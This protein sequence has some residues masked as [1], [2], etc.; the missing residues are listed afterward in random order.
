MGAVLAIQNYVT[1]PLTANSDFFL[2]MG[3]P[4]TNKLLDSLNPNTIKIYS[5]TP[6]GPESFGPFQET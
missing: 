2:L 5:F 1:T 6:T 4:E 3:S